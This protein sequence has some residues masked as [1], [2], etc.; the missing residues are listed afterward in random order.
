MMFDDVLW[1]S[2]M[3]YDVLWCSMMFYD[4]LWCSMMFYDF[5]K[6]SMMFH[7]VLWCSTMFYDVLWCSMM[8]YDVLWCSMMFFVLRAFLVSLC[9]S[10][11]PDFFQSFFI[12]RYISRYLISIGRNPDPVVNVGKWVRLSSNKNVHISSG[13][14]QSYWKSKVFIAEI[15]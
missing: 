1:C 13:L 6:C 10:V 3:F 4:A 2:M 9:Q 14:Y 12:F 5:L 8:F 15:F 11:P 7:D